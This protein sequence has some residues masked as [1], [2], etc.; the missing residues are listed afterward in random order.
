MMLVL[1]VLHFHD[2][3][4]KS[5]QPEKLK[6]DFMWENGYTH[7]WVAMRYFFGKPQEGRAAIANDPDIRRKYVTELILKSIAIFGLGL[8]I[9]LQPVCLLVWNAVT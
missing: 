3:M 5:N 4:R 6:E 7:S 8:L 2:I 9:L 1:G